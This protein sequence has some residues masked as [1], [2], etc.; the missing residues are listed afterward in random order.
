MKEIRLDYQQQK[1]TSYKNRNFILVSK[2]ALISFNRGTSCS[3]VR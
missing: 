2:G 3:K 1:K